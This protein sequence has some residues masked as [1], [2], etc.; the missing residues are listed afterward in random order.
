MFFAYMGLFVLY[1]R[2]VSGMSILELI[3]LGVGLAMDAFAVAICK[4]LS[5]SKV[6]LKQCFLI[7]LFFGGFQALMPVL[8][9]AL[10]STFAEKIKN[11]D[12]WIAF[13]LLAYVGISMIADAIKERGES[14]SVEEMDLPLDMKELFLLAI[15]TSIDAMAAGITLSFFEVSIALAAAIIGG[16]TFMISGAGVFVG[17]IF[18][19]KYK[20]KAQI[21]GGVILVVLGLR[22]LI[23]HLMGLE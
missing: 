17:N 14:V 2:N 23:T 6:N 3:L 21:L 20:S 9:W 18:G 10:A 7:A 16:V 11:V 8:G 12:H 5:M 19:E 4:G 1:E 22:I 15:A 13:L